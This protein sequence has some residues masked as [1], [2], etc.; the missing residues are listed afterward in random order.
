MPSES[1]AD[2]QRRLAWREKQS[3]F[4]ATFAS[5]SKEFRDLATAKNDGAD[6]SVVARADDLRLRFVK[7]CI[8]ESGWSSVACWNGTFARDI[9]EKLSSIRLRLGD[10]VGAAAE[11]H[12]RVSYPDLRSEDAKLAATKN[13]V[14]LEPAIRTSKELLALDSV[15]WL[16]VNAP[17]CKR[18]ACKR[19][20]S[21][22]R[23]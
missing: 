22:A 12:T 10:A 20:F 6:A 4:D 9:T 14:S 5:E 1:E 3:A 19:G 7:H 17:R 15:D 2:A 8:A 11:F 23:C 18:R 21:A 13:A 16:M